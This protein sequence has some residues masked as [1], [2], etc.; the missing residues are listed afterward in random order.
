[1]RETKRSHY[2]FISLDCFLPRNDEI[3]YSR[4]IIELYF[5][6]MSSFLKHTFLNPL[7][8]FIHDSRA[9]GIM[10]LGCT[11]I[12]LMAAN[13]PFTKEW[14]QHLWA[15][16]FDGTT[17]HH[18]HI[19]L[20]S[21]PNSPLLIIN[22]LLMA[23][24]FFLAG[25][26]IKREMV[27]GELASFKKSIL[28]VAAAIGGMAV[29]AILFAT[30]NK[31]TGYTKGW[32]IPTATDI[33]F[34]LGIA[35]L[36][37]NRV[38]VALKIFLTALAIIDDL[39]AIVVIALFY[40]GKLKLL[41]LLGCTGI[42]GLLLLM[43]KL[44]IKFGIWNFVLG[45]LL[46]YCMFNSGIHATVAGVVFAFL[47]P[48]KY[49]ENFELKLHAPVYFI[50]MPIFAL[51]NTAIEFPTNML[52]SL[53]GTL[54][55]GIII[56]LFVGKPAGICLGSFILIKTKLA[57]LPTDTNWHQILGAGMLAGIGFT[58]SIFIATLAFTSVVEQDI[59]KISVLLASFIA[60]LI[61]YLWLKTG[62]KKVFPQRH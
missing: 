46:W 47:V 24:F 52:Q 59:A 3:N 44:K 37:G 6:A 22:D 42:V 58:M 26:E 10:L 29:P 5:A 53:S 17:A 2:K 43:N 16:S 36:L 4:S 14:Y 51:A 30:I 34:T 31:G 7:S 1:M 38:P 48:T 32:A 39:G 40:G 9:I 50:I 21:L 20:L 15:F 28:P 35:S 11:F 45:I 61:G 60:M 49:L 55:W 56:G 62:T 25:M 54:S 57:E 13:I 18:L 12:S 27:A 19:G 23:V 33:A 8:E 41:Y